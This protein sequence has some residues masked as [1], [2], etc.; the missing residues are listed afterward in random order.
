MLFVQRGRTMLDAAASGVNQVISTHRTRE[1]RGSIPRD[2]IPVT[3]R[4]NGAL[5]NG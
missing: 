2:A 3:E 4:R 5:S 1:P